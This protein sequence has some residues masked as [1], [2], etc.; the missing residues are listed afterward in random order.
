M[1]MIHVSLEGI[2]RTSEDEKA[3]IHQIEK[4]TQQ[5]D[6]PFETD[7]GIGSI[8]IC[9]CGIIDVC[10]ENYYAVLKTNTAL[11]GPGY[12]AFVCEL[13][14]KI[15]KE[16]PV[17]LSIDDECDYL[18]DHDL[19]RIRDIAFYP[20]M[21]RLMES[22]SKMKEDEEATYAW[23]NKSYLPI[24]KEKSIITPL[25]YVYAAQCRNLS[26]EEACRQ[27]Y[28]WNE[29]EKDALFYRNSALVSLWCDCLFENSLYDE[30][31]LSLAK[32]ICIALEKAHELDKSL[33]LPVDEYQLLCKMLKREN[34]IFDVD[35]YPQ[36]DIGY[37]KNPVFYVYGN[38]F[39]YFQ[40]NAI[41]RFDGHTMILE[42]MNEEETLISMSITGY[43]DNKKMDFAYRYLNTVDSL[44]NIDFHDEGIHIKGVLHQLNDEHHTLYL[45]A[46]CIKEN[47]MLMINVQCSD[48]TSYQQALHTLENM[49]MIRMERSEAD[50]K[51]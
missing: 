24:A 41:Q 2:V 19:N 32:S 36:G 48:M 22:F 31:S 23:E 43:K 18:Q 40:G 14:D 47:E 39:I 9:P 1:F 46:Q 5:Y 7:H 15:Q 20:Y 3:L 12:H 29:I 13:F 45:Q 11:A 6:L 25:G 37:R 28:I 4:V 49:Q 8:Y 21:R 30:A 34:R 10:I 35:Q 16:G 26:I 38:W 17:Y 33:P 27:F 50:V 44:D 42:I 51:V